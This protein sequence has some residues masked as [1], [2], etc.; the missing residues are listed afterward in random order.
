LVTW[1][2]VFGSDWASLELISNE[3]VGAGIKAAF[4]YFYGEEVDCN[5]L[6]QCA[7]IVFNMNK[8]NIDEARREY[9]QR[10]EDGKKAQEKRRNKANGE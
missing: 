8:K 10:V 2:K 3:D 1:W 4:M 9:N 6:P 5:S 7:K